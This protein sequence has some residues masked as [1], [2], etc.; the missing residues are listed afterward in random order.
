MATIANLSDLVEPLKREV[1]APGG[2][3]AAFPDADDDIMFSYLA[4]AFGEAQLDLYLGTNTVDLVTGE[5]QD[6]L[7]LGEGALV[8][9]YAALKIFNTQILNSATKATYKAGPVEYSTSASDRVLTAAI[10]NL[11]ARK[12]RLLKT[13]YSSPMW[14]ADAYWDRIMYS[15]SSMHWYDQHGYGHG[16]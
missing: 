4:D 7:T 8:V 2:F 11:Q 14:V 5:F 12:D 6:E 13:G 3:E 1:A 15:P 16:G 10:Q 9:I